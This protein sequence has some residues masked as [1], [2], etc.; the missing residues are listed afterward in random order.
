MN[1]AFNAGEIAANPAA[2]VRLPRT[3]RREMVRLTKDQFLLL[4]R[5]LPSA[6]THFLTSWWP[7]GRRFSEATALTPA[8]VDAVNGSVPITKGWKKTQGGYELGQPKSQRSIRTVSVPASVLDRLD[9]AKDW[10]L[11]NTD[12]GPTRLYSWRSNV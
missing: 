8:D 1:L 6:G 12:G 7:S 2:G 4:K 3:P 5:P 11:T 9:L 10:V